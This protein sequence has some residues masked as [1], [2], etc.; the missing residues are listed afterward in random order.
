MARN[1]QFS[2]PR[3]RSQTRLIIQLVRFRNRDA[4]RVV[5]AADN[6]GVITGTE[7]HEDDRLVVVSRARPV[8][9]ISIAFEAL[10][11]DFDE[12]AICVWFTR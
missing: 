4:G 10:Q 9:W 7:R 1:A 6:G 3:C 11:L 5:H 8:F 12:I 2:T